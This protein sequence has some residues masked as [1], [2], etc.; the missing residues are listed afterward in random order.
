MPSSTTGGDS[1]MRE[2][3]S[4]LL[5]TTQSRSLCPCI[6]SLRHLSSVNTCRSDQ[7]HL[8]RSRALDGDDACARCLLGCSAQLTYLQHLS[9][10]GGREVPQPTTLLL[11]LVLV[12]TRAEA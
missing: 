5:V 12:A 3:L 2:A 9:A 8:Q 6:S 1:D 11:F 10:G 4:H 7:Q